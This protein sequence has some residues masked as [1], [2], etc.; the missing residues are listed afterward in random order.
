MRTSLFI[1]T[2]LCTSS[3]IGAF[4]VITAPNTRSCSSITKTYASTEAPNE[5]KEDVSKPAPPA[6]IEPPK[7][8]LP[9]ADPNYRNV[10]SVGGED[11]IVTR[12]GPPTKDELSNEN[13]LKILVK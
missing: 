1:S 11:F 4:V 12:T 13:L 10:G 3:A 7:P 5:G 2:L 8:F 9:A 6:V